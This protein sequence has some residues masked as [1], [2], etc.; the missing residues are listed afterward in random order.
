MSSDELGPRGREIYDSLVTPKLDPARKAIVLEAARTADRL[1]DL[2]QIIAGKGVLKLMMFRVLNKQIDE[3]FGEMSLTVDVNFA[4]PLTEA[5]MQAT[6]LTGLLK[7][8]QQLDPANAGE[9]DGK[10]KTG[11]SPED[12]LAQKRAEREAKRRQAAQ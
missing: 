8:F 5:R 1:D 6:A 2:H 10:P 7:S 11:P 4:T 9:E 3:E 12:I